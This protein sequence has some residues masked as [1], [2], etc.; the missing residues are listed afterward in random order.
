VADGAASGRT[1]FRPS[2]GAAMTATELVFGASTPC[3]MHLVNAPEK[4]RDFRTPI[5]V[6][7]VEYA[8]STGLA[9]VPMLSWFMWHHPASASTQ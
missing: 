7:N 9:P 6:R 1:W 4:R 8:E 2:G 5:L 3:L